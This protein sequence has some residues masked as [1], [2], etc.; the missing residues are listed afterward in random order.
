[1]SVDYAVYRI[2]THKLRLATLNELQTVYDTSD[3]YDFLEIM[4]AY[5][6]TRE[7]VAKEEPKR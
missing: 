4:D 3:I 2:L 5:D 7:V 1:M 6:F